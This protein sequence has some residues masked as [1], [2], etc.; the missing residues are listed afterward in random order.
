MAY[1]CVSERFPSVRSLWGLLTQASCSLVTRKYLGTTVVVSVQQDSL[2]SEFSLRWDA[3]FLLD[4]NM[5][6]CTH[7]F[8]RHLCKYMCSHCLQLSFTSKLSCGKW[9]ARAWCEKGLLEHPG[10][11][12]L[13]RPSLR[14]LSP[15]LGTESTMWACKQRACCMAGKEREFK[16]PI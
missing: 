12:H 2:Q 1:V 9:A 3:W 14:L 10:A 7:S 11:G 15:V 5:L 8:L 4:I 16:P 6:E 13:I